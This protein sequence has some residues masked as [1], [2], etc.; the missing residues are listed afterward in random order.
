MSLGSLLDTNI[1]NLQE[2]S[3]TYTAEQKALKGDVEATAAIREA[4]RIFAQERSKGATAFSLDPGKPA[5]RIEEF[6]QTSEPGVH[7]RVWCRQWRGLLGVSLHLATRWPVPERHC[8]GQQGN[9]GAGGSPGGS[10][11]WSCR[12]GMHWRVEELVP[13]LS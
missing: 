2:Q 11:A 13:S 3:L 4:E 5:Q 10:K 1:E 8:A 12:V 7:G 9:T 6:D